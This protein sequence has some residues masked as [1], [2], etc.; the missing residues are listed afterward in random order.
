ME[1]LQC[2][3]PGSQTVELTGGRGSGIWILMWLLVKRQEL[4][5]LLEIWPVLSDSLHSNMT[6]FIEKHLSQ[7]YLKLNMFKAI[8][9]PRT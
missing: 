8:Y 5:E 1:V 6:V 3:A 9:I 7:F 4:L 2:P